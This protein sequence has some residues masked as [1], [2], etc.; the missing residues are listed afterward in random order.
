MREKITAALLAIALVTSV[1]FVGLAGPAAAQT[2]YDVGI[3]VAD[4]LVSS[5]GD[6]IQAPKCRL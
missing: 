3:D 4:G 1:A 6:T 5:N 2:G